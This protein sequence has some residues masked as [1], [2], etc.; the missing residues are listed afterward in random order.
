[1]A[2]PAS[3]KESVPKK[4]EKWPKTVYA[5]YSHGT[6][7]RVVHSQEELD[8]FLAHGWHEELGA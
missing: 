8:D 4:Q 7:H 2:D 1:M 5:E 6:A 3:P